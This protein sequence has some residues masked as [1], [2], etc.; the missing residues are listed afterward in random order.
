[1]I[2][3]KN[4]KIKYLILFVCILL[5]C[6]GCSKKPY[7]DNYTIEYSKESDIFEIPTYVLAKDKAGN[8]LK[9]IQVIPHNMKYQYS[10][11]KMSDPDENGNVTVSYRV[12]MKIDRE[13]K[14]KKAPSNWALNINYI[15]QRTYFDYYTGQIL[16]EN[17]VPNNNNTT[18]TA[19]GIEK[20]KEEM[21]YN[22]INIDGKEYKIGIM[23]KMLLFEA[24]DTVDL[25]KDG[26]YYHYSSPMD[27]AIETY[28]EMP[29]NY[30]G[31]R[32][33]LNKNGTTKETYKKQMDDYNKL[34]SLQEDEQKTGKKSQELIDLENAN[35]AVHKIVDSED[36]TR[37]DYNF[38]DYYIINPAEIFN[39]KSDIG[40]TNYL[41]IIIVAIIVIAA[42][43]VLIIILSIVIILKKKKKSNI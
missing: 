19:N 10:N 26:E 30:D 2:K 41:P 11:W 25:G 5:L 15:N 31:L 4:K 40:K 37:K 18:V 38:D 13:Y 42:V 24:Q 23:T 27:I 12:D 16:K 3:I 34:V 1:M 29:A 43:L 6:T 7:G 14:L 17:Y 39:I 28:I 36:E 20:P 8:E 33:A 32:I 21:K 22:I 35:N 9:E